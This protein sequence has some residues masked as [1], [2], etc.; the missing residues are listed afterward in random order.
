MLERFY[1]PLKGS[2]EL[3][4][5]DIKEINVSHLRSVIGYV[6]QEPTLFATTIRG[7]IQYGNPNATQAQI[8]E[9]ARMA[10][11]HDFITSFSDGYDTQVGDKGSQLSGGQKQ[12]I[13]IARV[14]V[15]NPKIL[16]LDEATSGELNENVVS[17]IVS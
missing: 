14:L 11:A 6:G 13:A 4:G 16:L 10:N 15:A 5:I 1:D 12:R 2:I 7:N 3:D 9:A 17:T 8:E